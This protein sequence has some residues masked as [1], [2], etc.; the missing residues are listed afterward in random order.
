MIKHVRWKFY[1]FVACIFF[2]GETSL[3]KVIYCCFIIEHE[4]LEANDHTL[5]H[6]LLFSH[7]I[8]TRPLSAK[9]LNAGF[10]ILIRI[11]NVI[12]L[13]NL[14]SCTQCYCVFTN[15]VLTNAIYH[16]W[17]IDLHRVQ[18]SNLIGVTMKDT[19]LINMRTRARQEEKKRKHIQSSYTH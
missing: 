11:Y 13:K 19:W 18:E 7:C 14:M 16:L 17:D 4:R 10:V 6:A 15:P 8:K 2:Q 9:T 5:P 12:L 1:I 3:I